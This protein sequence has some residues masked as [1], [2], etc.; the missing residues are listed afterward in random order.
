MALNLKNHEVERLVREVTLMTGES[1]TVAVLQAL[2]ERKERLQACKNRER[3]VRGLIEFLT[4]DVW[5]IP[6]VAGPPDDEVLGFG[7]SGA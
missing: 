5:S 1:K 4:D 6:S 3:D 2:R 7:E